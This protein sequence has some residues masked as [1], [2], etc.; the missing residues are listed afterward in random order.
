MKFKERL[1]KNME[2]KAKILEQ[3]PIRVLKIAEYINK[4]MPQTVKIM[5]INGPLQLNWLKDNQYA[6]VLFDI[7]KPHK[8][9]PVIVKFNENNEITSIKG[10]TEKAQ[11]KLNQWI[12]KNSV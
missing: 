11:E 8:V 9:V 7:N 10:H 4:N 2:K 6:T 5:E 3:E 1:I 12:N